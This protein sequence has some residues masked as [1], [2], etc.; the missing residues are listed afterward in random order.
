ME[1]DAYAFDDRVEKYLRTIRAQHPDDKA[2]L[3]EAIRQLPSELVDPQPEHA[4]RASVLLKA[5]AVLITG[6]LA[7]ARPIIEL[8]LLPA[9]GVLWFVVWLSSPFNRRK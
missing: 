3:Q 8:V 9:I 7:L 6:I 5:V 2:F 4:R 1:K